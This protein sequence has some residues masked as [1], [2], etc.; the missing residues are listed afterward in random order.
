MQE[1]TFTSI[2]T[3]LSK[4]STVLANVWRVVTLR[5]NWSKIVGSELVECSLPLSLK[6]GRLV[7]L[8]SDPTWNTQ[9][10]FMKHKILEDC[11]RF[12]NG[13]YVKEI[14]FRVREFK[15]GR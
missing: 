6:G 9:L 14:H 2:G 3:I 11:Q 13:D 12:L 8:V 7:V 15:K 4:E 10:Q 1:D 5:K